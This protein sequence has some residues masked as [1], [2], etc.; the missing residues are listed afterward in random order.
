MRLSRLVGV[1]SKTGSGRL[2]DQLPEELGAAGGRGVLRFH[3]EQFANEGT[4][5]PY[6]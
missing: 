1:F 2:V 3:E 5:L 4:A 6:L